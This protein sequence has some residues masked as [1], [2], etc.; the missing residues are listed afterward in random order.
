[1]KISLQNC[2]INFNGRYIRRNTDYIEDLLKAAGSTDVER[3]VDRFESTMDKFAGGLRDEAIITLDF[4]GGYPYWVYEIGPVKDIDDED[5][6]SQANTELGIRKRIERPNIKV[7]FEHLDKFKNEV[8]ILDEKIK[9]NKLFSPEGFELYA[10]LRKSKLLSEIYWSGNDNMLKTSEIIKN[11]GE[12]NLASIK[13]LLQRLKMANIGDVRVSFSNKF[14][15]KS[16]DVELYRKYFEG[17]CF[18]STKNTDDQLRRQGHGEE[19][20]YGL[21]IFPA[22]MPL[23]RISLSKNDH[24]VELLIPL[25][26]EQLADKNEELSADLIQHIKKELENQPKTDEELKIRDSKRQESWDSWIKRYKE[27]LN[28]SNTPKLYSVS[29]DGFCDQLPEI[30]L[31]DIIG[32]DGTTMREKYGNLDK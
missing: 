8:K 23:M 20:N 17:S 16:S 18:L 5:D 32:P 6:F 13:P 22:E 2:N 11:V 15:V 26:E 31:G 4:N 12:K 14:F 10:Y 9:T 24:K 1:M 29:T 27:M 3:D 21:T 25:D 19:L 28:D 30:N 7:S